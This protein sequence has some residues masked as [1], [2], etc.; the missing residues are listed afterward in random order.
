MA[1]P[2]D[3]ETIQLGASAAGRICAADKAH[4]RGY[5]ASGDKYVCRLFPQAHTDAD[6]ACP[7]HESRGNRPDV[8]VSGSLLETEPLRNLIFALGVLADGPH[9]TMESALAM[10]LR[11]SWDRAASVVPG[12][13]QLLP[14]ALPSL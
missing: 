13:W 10:S 12:S 4:D 8:A 2:S 11:L 6:E 7:P 14:A 5:H 9:W 1:S 3:R